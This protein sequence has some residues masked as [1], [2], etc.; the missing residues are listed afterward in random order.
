MITHDELV[1][2][3]ARMR[4]RWGRADMAFDG[5]LMDLSDFYLEALGV[6]PA[7]AWR[8]VYDDEASMYAM[9]GWR[10]V[11]GAVTRAMH[12][13]AWPRIEA[14]DARIGDLGLIRLESGDLAGVI[15]AAPGRWLGR[16]HFGF[17]IWPTQLGGVPIV[18][19][20]WSIG[21]CRR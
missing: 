11:L 15:C 6:D 7:S 12:D 2:A 9:L 13:V 5:C 18:C 14:G 10:G 8:G 4:A 21:P 3:M 1:T 20:V 19:R 17:S 16:T